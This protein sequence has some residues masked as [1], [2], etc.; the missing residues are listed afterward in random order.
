[1]KTIREEARNIKVFTETEVLVVGGGPAGIAAAIASARSGA[2]TVLLERYGHLGG[3]ATGGLVIMIPFMSSG[4][5]ER[6]IAGICQEL[7][8]RLDEIGGALHPADDEVGSTDKKVVDYW[9]RRASGTFVPGGSVSYGALVDPEKL[10]CILND[11]VTEAGVRLVLHSWGTRAVVE[12]GSIKGV[13]FESKSGR[14][15]VLSQVTIDTTGDGDVFASAGSEY[16]GTID[17]SL[18]SSNLALVFRIG[19]VDGDR[20]MDFQEQ[21]REKHEELMR[22]L[23]ARGGFNTY[24]RTPRDDVFWCNNWLP[25]L[26]AVDVEDLTYVEVS[27]RKSM[28]ISMDFLRKHVPGFKNSYIMDTASQTGT[29][30]S[31]R[32]TGEHVVTWDEVISGVIHPDTIAILP[33]LH[34]NP[35]NGYPLVYMPYRA[36]VPKNPEDLLVAGRCFSSDASANNS[37]NW[38]QQCIPMGQA[39]GTAAAIAVRSGISP[40]AVDYTEL[41]QKLT[42][43]GVPL[44][45]EITK[46]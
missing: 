9:R 31:R 37:L 6:Q 30:G 25:N 15:A 13:I 41:Q 23:T 20:Y 33:H 12:D 21:Q 36:L 43:Q 42:A 32:L 44:P 27:A 46:E 14:Q 3:M 17:R 16:D 10:K 2:R 19:G 24:W 29:R 26:S 38:I 7:I 4:T 11:I 40:K 22:E 45:G 18:R 5:R 39:A 1:M 8:D 28:L 35:A 34:H